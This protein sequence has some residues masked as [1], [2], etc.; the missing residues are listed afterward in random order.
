MLSTRALLAAPLA[1]KGRYAPSFVTHV[2]ATGTT[3]SVPAAARPGD[4]AVVW[5]GG[6][7]TSYSETTGTFTELAQYSSAVRPFSHVF[8]ALLPDPVPSS[9]TFN[10]SECG[11][12]GI[13]RNVDQSTPIDVDPPPAITN[14]DVSPNITT[15]ENRSLI[16]ISCLSYRVGAEKPVAPAGYTNMASIFDARDS[17]YWFATAYRGSTTA[18]SYT[19]GQWVADGTSTPYGSYYTSPNVMSGTIAIRGALIP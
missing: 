12:M 3:Y 6:E 18:G 2:T 13:F 5:T 14:T 19:G 7:Y 1:Y 9:Y 11:I 8:Y 10:V 15:A 17:N 4:L 16:A